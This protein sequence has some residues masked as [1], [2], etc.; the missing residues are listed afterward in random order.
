MKA[1]TVLTPNNRSFYNRTMKEVKD[2]APSD[3]ETQPEPSTANLQSKIKKLFRNKKFRII[4]GASLALIVVF[5]GFVLVTQTGGKESNEAN[6][7]AVSDDSYVYTNRDDCIIHFRGQGVEEND[8]LAKCIELETNASTKIASNHFEPSTI[9]CAPQSEDEWYRTGNTFVVDPKNPNNLY[10]SVEWKG[11][12]KSTDGGKTWTLKTNGI[13]TDFIDSQTKKPCYPEYP[14]AVIDPSNPSRILLATSGGGGGTLKDQNMHGGGV[15]ETTDGGENWKQKINDTM[16]GYVTHALV[17]DPKNSQTFY[18]GTSASPASYDEAD[19]NK[20]WVSKGVIYKTAD[21]GKNWSELPTGIIKNV[22]LTYINVDPKDSNKLTA[23]SVVMVHNPN[24][25][26]TV[27]EEQLGI[28][29]STD[30][31]KTW[32]RIDNLPN[33]YVGALMTA[34]SKQNGNN[35]FHVAAVNGGTPGKSFF[36]TDSGKTWTESTKNLDLI[37]YDPNDAS[38]NRIL[39]YIWQCMGTCVKTLQESNDAGRTWHTFGTLPNEIVTL[40]DRKTRIQNIVWHP[41]DKN[42]IFLT[43]ANGY[44]WKSTDNGTSWSL[45]LS[46]DKL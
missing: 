46:V 38:G 19:P 23:D 45:L 7:V 20:I 37:A 35:M 14:V 29:Q 8:A 1:Y 41:T 2:Q 16:N 3:P 18:Y 13:V 17:L 36:T 42:T 27:S 11:F 4:G 10:V 26:N 40:Q 34:G 15:Y 12:H 44:V 32:K 30:G 28:I 21:N 22:R 31:G 25:P 5:I 43:G 33:G 39:G 9:A 6:I 24:G